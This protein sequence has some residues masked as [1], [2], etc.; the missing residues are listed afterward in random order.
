MP[1]KPLSLLKFVDSSS[2]D[3]FCD[4]SVLLTYVYTYSV[5]CLN[6]SLH[7]KL[8]RACLGEVLSFSC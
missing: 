6:V 5:V 4:K 7:A 1:N 8:P 3:D 2:V